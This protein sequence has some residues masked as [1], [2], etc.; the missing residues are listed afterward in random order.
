MALGE[1]VE[2]EQRREAG[3]EDEGDKDAELE[4]EARDPVCGKDV[5]LTRSSSSIDYGGTTYYFCSAECEQDFERTP[6]LFVPPPE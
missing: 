4:L 3:A 6:E 1:F 5:V 2:R